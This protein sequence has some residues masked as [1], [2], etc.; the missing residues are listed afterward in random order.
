[1]PLSQRARVRVGGSELKQKGDKVDGS[2][3]KRKQRNGEF[4]RSREL[5]SGG[6]Y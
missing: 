4:F 2:W 3:K 1:V 6:D 5:V